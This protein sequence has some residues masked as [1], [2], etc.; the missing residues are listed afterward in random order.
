MV[1][2]SSIIIALIPADR[3]GITRAR[4]LRLRVCPNWSG[5]WIMWS[6][7]STELPCIDQVRSSSTAHWGG[8]SCAS[9]PQVWKSNHSPSAIWESDSVIT[10]DVVVT[11]LWVPNLFGDN[12]GCRNTSTATSCRSAIFA[13]RNFSALAI[14]CGFAIGNNHLFLS[15]DECHCAKI[16]KCVRRLIRNQR[17]KV[18]EIRG[19][20]VR[21]SSKNISKRSAPTVTQA[22]AE[23]AIRRMWTSSWKLSIN[24][25]QVELQRWGTQKSRQRSRTLRWNVRAGIGTRYQ[26]GG[27]QRVQAVSRRGSS[28]WVSCED[29]KLL[30]EFI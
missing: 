29:I 17:E 6:W 25:Q 10:F 19:W 2:A 9:V 26:S 30:G 16:C 13:W 27:V 1:A 22:K 23:F 12:M 24:Q 18:L 5:I 15:A 28:W 11:C 7:S 4:M 20:Q 8:K 3:A 21:K 14:G